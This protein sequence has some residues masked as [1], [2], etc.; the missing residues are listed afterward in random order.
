VAAE[1]KESFCRICEPLCGTVATVEDGELIE[2]RSNREHPIS[3]G[4]AC[5]KGIAMKEIVNDPDRLLHP[6]RRKPG[7]PPG[8]AGPDD[9]ERVSWD[10]AISEIGARLR[11][12]IDRHGG[13]SVG[14]YVGNPAYFS[15]STPM[16]T[17]GFLDALGSDHYYAPNSQD[18]A[19]RFAASALLYG[20]AFAVPVPDLYRTDFMLMV[21]AN[22]LLSHGSLIHTKRIPD[23]LHAIPK[24][25]GRIVVVDPRR[26]ETARAFEHVPVNPDTDAWMLL[27]M[28]NVIFAEGLEDSDALASQTRGVDELRAMA[29]PHPPARTEVRTGVPAETVTELARAFA[30]AP[31]AC[32]YGR[33]G[34]NRGR[35]G[36]L[37][38][39]LL[40][41]L[42][43]VTGNLDREGGSI[44]GGMPIPNSFLKRTD[45]YASKRTRV[46]G[47]PDAFGMVC[48]VVM[49]EEMRTPGPGQLRAFFTIAGNPLL[50]VPDGQALASAMEGLDLYVAIDLYLSDTATYADYVLPGTTFY[51][52]EDISL[53]TQSFHLTPHLEWTDAVI[54]PRGESRQEW[55]AIDAIAREIGVVPA[56]DP[57]VRALGKLG[58]RMKPERMIDVALRLG[59]EGDLFGLRRGGLSVKKLRKMPAGVVLADSQPTGVLRK[60]VRHGDK[61][62]HLDAPEILEE[63]RRL[64]ERHTEDPRF[65]LMMIGLREL[66]SHNS[67]MHNSPKLMSGKRDHVARVHPDDAAAAGVADG[68]TIRISTATNSIELPARLTDEII[69]GA[70]AVPH[71]WGHSGG[72]RVANRSAG[73]NVNLLAS[74][75]V[76]DIERLAGMALLDGI[77]ARID[78]VAVGDLRDRQSPAEPVGAG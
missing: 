67:W 35:H 62:V 14:A 75:R 64:G 54:P 47:F 11:T 42:S 76:E 25:G 36:T 77:P 70:I 51:E 13:S 9:F 26:T 31:S 37:V 48:S 61:R 59:S 2:L 4:F 56:S 65:P 45:T 28:L 74:S 33:C 68:D 24:R 10:Q 34:S 7:T 52:R 69:A 3:Q 71:G 55:E 49:A 29:E 53:I 32:A 1:H 5:P 46:G 6:L 60:R 41:A 17:Q 8:P 63:S 22:P 12:T 19:S 50:T 40:D 72:W 58:L 16:W 44:I 66:R 18:T 27:S 15:Y 78:A 73:A 43:I 38:A 20:S 57:T 39:Y 23:T 21:G 30:S